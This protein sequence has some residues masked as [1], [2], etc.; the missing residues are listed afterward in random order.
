MPNL[1]TV[2]KEEIK[3][4]SRRSTAALHRPLKKDVAELKRVVAQQKR[5]IESLR[6][7]SRRLMAD[8]NGRIAKLP[9]VSEK[10][11]QRIRLS[12]R[13]IASQR[14]RLGLTQDEFGNLL[15]VS[16]HSVFLWEHKKASPRRKVKAAFAVVRTL[17]RR[18]ARQR[19]EAMAT[20]NGKA[21]RAG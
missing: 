14:K 21:H 13:I 20:V 5:V 15:G 19:L 3:R 16:G 7:D 10:D 4:L 6:R 17:G 12:S 11:A 18:E 1:G 2:L 9:A 8:L